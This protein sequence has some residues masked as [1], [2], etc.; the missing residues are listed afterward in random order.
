MFFS[1]FYYFSQSFGKPTFKG[2]FFNIFLFNGFGFQKL[3][4]IFD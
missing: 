2:V 4:Q 1:Y 3:E